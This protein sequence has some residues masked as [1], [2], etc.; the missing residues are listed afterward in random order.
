MKRRGRIGLKNKK[1][2]GVMEFI[3]Y[4]VIV[5]IFLG[6]MA[7]LFYNLSGGGSG[8]VKLFRDRF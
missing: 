8:L 6:L 4:L 1:A 3:I 5:I 7:F 2:M